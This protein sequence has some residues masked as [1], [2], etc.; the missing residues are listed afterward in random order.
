LREGNAGRVVASLEAA[1]DGA[2]GL[3]D[4]LTLICMMR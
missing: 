2:A 4:D 1:I 3:A